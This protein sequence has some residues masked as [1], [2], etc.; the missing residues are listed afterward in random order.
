MRWSDILLRLRALSRRRDMDE[1]RGGL[2]KVA[3]NESS[4]TQYKKKARPSVFLSLTIEAAIVRSAAIVLNL[5]D[6][7]C[8][9]VNEHS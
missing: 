1:V 3:M 2:L 6:R 9:S 7:Q 4:C 8:R 5:I